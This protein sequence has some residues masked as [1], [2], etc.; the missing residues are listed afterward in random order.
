MASEM[1]PW[2]YE[3]KC[4]PDDE[5]SHA[6]IYDDSGEFTAVM[7]I[8]K[9]KQI[10]DAMN[11]CPAPVATDTGLVTYAHDNGTLSGLS[12]NEHGPWC[13][14]SQAE[15]IIAAERAEKE[16]LAALIHENGT[17][18]FNAVCERAEKAEAEAERWHRKAMDA[19]VIVHSD[20]TT[21]HPMRKERDDL[22]ADN[23]EKDREIGQLKAALG[24]DAA[25]F[26]QSLVDECS[27]EIE[28]R[29]ALE[30]K[31]AAANEIAQLVIQAEEDKSGDPNFYILMMQTAY[32]KARAM[33]G[34]KSS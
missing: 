22:K 6:W 30:A 7:K 34:G 31:L 4:G 5:A 20:G 32:D 24:A 9:A 27:R 10:V 21:S 18:R 17:P 16:R 1:K 14:R 12:R 25:Q 23:A 33:L 11:T 28:K 3:I 26:M 29:K 2:R 15:A 19:G 13:L 8:H